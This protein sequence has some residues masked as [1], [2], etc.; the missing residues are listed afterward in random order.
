MG[1]TRNTTTQEAGRPRRPAIL[2][3]NAWTPRTASLV[4]GTALVLLAVLAGFGF[5]AIMPLVTPGDA[6]ATARD[7]SA[8][9]PLF[10]AG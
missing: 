2:T 7:I 5:G 6:A 10:L 8:A 3:F 9:R 1:T 4:A